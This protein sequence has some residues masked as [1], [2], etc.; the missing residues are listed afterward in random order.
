MF[1]I[2]DGSGVRSTSNIRAVRG[3]N[4]VV[5]GT[6]TSLSLVHSLATLSHQKAPDA[7]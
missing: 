2:S 1:R 3:V 4:V 6:L 5:V 7:K